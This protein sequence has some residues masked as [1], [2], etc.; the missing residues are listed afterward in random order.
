[1]TEER[2]NELFSECAPLGVCVGSWKA[3]TENNAHAFG[4]EWKGA[5]YLD[6]NA[7][8]SPEELDEVL[9]FL[10][11]NEEEREELFVQDYETDKGI[12]LHDCDYLNPAHI[13]KALRDN[14][15]DME[16]DGEK[17]GAIIEVIND[18]I[19]E[20]IEK[21]NDYYF[22]ADIDAEEYEEELVEDCAGLDGIDGALERV[23]LGW[24]APYV[25]VDY[26]QLARDDGNIWEANGGV[27]SEA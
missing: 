10:G 7:L 14:D 21:A 27:L 22:R 15:I 8:E 26:E 1:M 12:E 9:A 6:I 2:I 16:E 11:W 13:I 25:S 23:G 24:L 20:A 19:L 4:C 3:Y 17:I 5:H 18:N